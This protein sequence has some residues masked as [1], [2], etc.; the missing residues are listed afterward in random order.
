MPKVRYSLRM[1]NLMT[2]RELVVMLAAP[3]FAAEQTLKGDMVTK[4]K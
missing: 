2:R 4:A 1:A 3:V